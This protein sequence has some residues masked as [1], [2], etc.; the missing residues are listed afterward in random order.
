MSIQRVSEYGSSPN[1]WM[2]RE[3]GCQTITPKCGQLLA[4][5]KRAAEESAEKI[6]SE[7]APR[8]QS[9]VRESI[10]VKF[11]NLFDHIRQNYDILVRQVKETR[12]LVVYVPKEKTDSFTMRWVV[13][14]KQQQ[15]EVIC[16]ITCRILGKGGEA[17]VKEVLEC[18]AKGY[19]RYAV[20]RPLDE[21]GGD[22]QTRQVQLIGELT[23]HGVPRLVQM[24]FWPHYWGKDGAK[25]DCVMMR[26]YTPYS[27]ILNAFG[28]KKGV[29]PVRVASLLAETLLCLH[30]AGVV[31]LDLK[32]ENVFLDDKQTPLLG[33]FGLATRVQQFVECPGSVGYRAPELLQGV[34]KGGTQATVQMDSWSFGVLLYF[35]FVRK[36][37]FF[38][39][40]ESLCK[41]IA[42]NNVAKQNFFWNDFCSLVNTERKGLINGAHR[43]DPRIASVIAS[44]LSLNPDDRMSD[45]RTLANLRQAE[46]DAQ[47]L[48]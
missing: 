10:L 23:S 32:P 27:T 41:A 2:G 3:A 21:Q 38:A 7:V 19:E 45:E 9:A 43:M 34:L 26:C 17:K 42:A 20:R 22:R 6:A 5:F 1:P 30:R 48:H 11:E 16:Y 39:V 31:H 40:Q 37:P 24:L 44:L 18:S 28:D 46:K 4:N 15:Q 14:P 13:P 36:S 33:D 35:S 25:K 47:A 29:D 8:F 12:H